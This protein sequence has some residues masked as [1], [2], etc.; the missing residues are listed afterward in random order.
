MN[1]KPQAIDSSKE[2]VDQ[3]MIKLRA[4]YAQKLPGKIDLIV[5]LWKKH[6]QISWNDE[7]FN[8]MY[9]LL[10][11]LAGSGKV[12]GYE[13]LSQRSRNIEKY[14]LNLIKQKQTPSEKD[15]LNIERLI[16][17][18][19]QLV[20]QSSSIEESKQSIDNQGRLLREKNKKMIFVVDDD[21]E[22]CRYTGMKLQSEGYQTRT[23]TDVGQA[24]EYMENIQPDLLVL[25]V[26]FSNNS[27]AG[28]ETVQA[29][30]DKS[31]KKLPIIFISAR[32]DLE[33]RARAVRVGGN[34]YLTKPFDF[35][36]LV[37]RIDEQLDIYKSSQGK[38]MIVDDE[39]AS[40][41][42]YTSILGRENLS[43]K[44]VSQPTEFMPKLS[45]FLPDVVIMD[46][47]M[48]GYNGLE[49]A[50]AMRQDN[51]FV[52]TPIIFLSADNKVEIQDQA[53]GL[54]VNEFVIKPVTGEQ[55][56]QVVQR[57]LATAKRVNSI[58]KTVSKKDR[59]GKASNNSYFM[60][61]LEI[62]IASA[63]KS[64]PYQYLFD[65][66]FKNPAI[67]SESLELDEI[68]TFNRILSEKLIRLSGENF[69]ISQ[70][71]DTV[72]MML[73]SFIDQGSVLSI[74]QN[75]ND[76]FAKVSIPIRDKNIKVAMDIGVV[77]INHHAM[78]VKQVLTEA[79]AAN[80]ECHQAKDRSCVITQ[81]NLSEE[82][83][84]EDIYD[85]VNQALQTSGMRLVYQPIVFTNNRGFEMYEAL[86]RCE[87]NNSATI[88]PAQ[89]LPLFQEK[90]EM[91]RIDKWVIESA[92]HELSNDTHAR[93]SADIMIKLSASSL[94][95]K[96]LVAMI[97]KL[98]VDGGIS[99]GKRIVFLLSELDVI[100]DIDYAVA[101]RDK[102]AKLDC[103]VG[104]DH[105]GASASSRELFDLLHPEYVKLHPPLLQKVME[106]LV[107]KETI[108]QL[109]NMANDG[110]AEVVA[111]G[112]ENP[113]MLSTLWTMGIRCFQG[114]FI[115]QP[116]RA[117]DFDFTSL[118]IIE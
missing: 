10:H 85:K 77:E 89:F 39:I 22:L 43:V 35:A 61:Q 51:R 31:L 9:R 34:A 3:S 7:A 41:N 87:V 6:T 80:L 49:L 42:F 106:N 8:V 102:V 97:S 47:H 67:I 115:K 70:F 21:H 72:Y 12:F 4:D 58:I 20:K 76:S 28:F 59:F 117:L 109:V 79:E 103:A 19:Q 81:L 100:D 33:A 24:L 14:L 83:E 38:V 23:F 48:Q 62:A 66:K 57:Q 86:L 96:Q 37:S 75:I 118:D 93:S 46:V 114:F 27:I 99:G 69:L 90:N 29:F 63:G 30:R 54:G 15:R 52:G 98:L 84:H 113:I 94:K 55:L 116:N 64:Q 44:V 105:F 73:S 95:E 50:A 91:W 36:E 92:I 107:A 40:S 60:E 110:K 78:S 45:E 65:I 32:T 26:M 18:L 68:E 17:S 104:I 111:C 56:N 82:T 1:S 16:N 101:F 88:Y 74:C 2:E 25:D 112:I 13:A 53:Y 108:R 11:G 5:K 71:S